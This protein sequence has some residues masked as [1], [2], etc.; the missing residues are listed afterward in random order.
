MLWIRSSS[1]IIQYIF[2]TPKVFLKYINIFLY[3]TLLSLLLNLKTKMKG[4]MT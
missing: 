4:K 1:I 2:F 3:K